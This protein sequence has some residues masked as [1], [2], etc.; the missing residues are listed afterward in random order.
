LNPISSTEAESLLI[1]WG[2]WVRGHSSLGYPKL[3]I[4][5]RV[6]LEGPGASHSTVAGEPHMPASIE[7]VERA[8]L[9]VFPKKVRKVCMHRYVGN[10]ADHTARKKL[11]LTQGEYEQ[12][13][14]QACHILADFMIEN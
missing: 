9:E 6:I 8:I 13:I 14:N 11:K 5:G 4:I 12:R 1:A 7:I 10:E 2:A 3:N